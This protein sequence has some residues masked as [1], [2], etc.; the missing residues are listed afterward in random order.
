MEMEKAAGRRGRQGKV[1]DDLN[2]EEMEQRTNHG[3][4][5]KK[6]GGITKDAEKALRD[7]I[8]FDDELRMHA[9][10]IGEVYEAIAEAALPRN[11][12]DEE[13]EEDDIKIISAAQLFEKAKADYATGYNSKSM[14]ERYVQ[15][16]Q[17]ST[18]CEHS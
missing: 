3:V 17:L 13:E 8:D 5:M 1:E 6:V 10:H 7:L 4:L 15:S 12:G 18:L 9:T 14:F 16:L 2:A 11:R